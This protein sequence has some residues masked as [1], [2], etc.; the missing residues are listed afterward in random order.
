[1]EAPGP[2]FA[3]AH[4]Q[5]RVGNGPQPGQPRPAKG[6]VG[7]ALEERHNLFSNPNYLR[8]PSAAPCADLDG[9]GVG[10]LVWLGPSSPPGINWGKNPAS[11]SAVSGKDGKDLWV[12]AAGQ[13]L[14]LGQPALFDVDGDGTPDLLVAFSS[15]RS[16]ETWIEALSGHDGRSLWRTPLEAAWFAADP[17]NR[18]IPTCTAR[19][20]SVDDRPAAVFAVGPRLLRLDPNTGRL[21]GTAHDLGFSPAGQPQFYA[22]AAGPAV[23]YLRPEAGERITLVAVSI[24]DGRPLWSRGVAV[25]WPALAPRQDL[26]HRPRP[27]NGPPSPTWTATAGQWSSCPT[28]TART[29]S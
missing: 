8:P 7:T 5:D 28:W 12:H 11:V 2:A 9:D 13:A 23:L 20:L 21:L 25:R 1:M 14:V 24:A 26:G 18:T 29:G 6:P 27:R 4:G 3:S 19:V 15:Q 22:T 10:D 17:A 16:P